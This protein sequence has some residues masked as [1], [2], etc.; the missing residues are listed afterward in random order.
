MVFAFAGDSTMTSFLAIAADTLAPRSNVASR[1]DTLVASPI[2][3]S[4]MASP[5]TTSLRS[6]VLAGCCAGSTASTRRASRTCRR[7]AGS[8][9]PRTTRRTSTRGRSGCRSGRNGSCSSWARSS[10]STRSLGPLLRAGGAFPVRRG[11]ADLEAIEKAV[12]DLPRRRRRRDVPGGDAPA[13]GAAQEVRAPAAHRLG[14]DR[15][16]PPAC[17]SSRPRSRAWTGSARLAQAEGRLRRARSR[18]TTCAELPPREAQQVATDR[19][20]E[21]IYALYEAL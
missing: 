10:C 12:R 9:S 4:A 17:R 15:V 13:E 3:L 16:R 2:L 21:R 14:A 5:S 19:L 8:S 11:E 6:P 7:R 18:S 20:M 1:R